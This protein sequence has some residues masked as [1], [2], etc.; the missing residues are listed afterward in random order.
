[1]ELN[2]LL[3]SLSGAMVVTCPCCG[4]QFD[5]DKEPEHTFSQEVMDAA[6]EFISSIG[7]NEARRQIER[8]RP[9]IQEAVTSVIDGMAATQKELTTK[10][11]TDA[12]AFVRCPHCWSRVYRS[13]SLLIPDSTEV[14][15]DKDAESGE[16]QGENIQNKSAD[17][18]TPS[19]SFW[20]ALNA[21]TQK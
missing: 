17:G 11:I 4:H 10:S 3:K 7:R 19:L 13:N 21:A 15:T 12:V 20:E 1:M 9:E 18:P 16:G 5:Y 2:L 8:Y 6:S 14:K